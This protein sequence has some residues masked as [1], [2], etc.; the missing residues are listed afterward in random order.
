MIA[1]SSGR[2]DGDSRWWQDESGMMAF[3]KSE[4]RLLNNCK[5]L[6]E[7]DEVL[8]TGTYVTSRPQSCW[9]DH[10][11]CVTI[12]AGQDCAPADDR[13]AGCLTSL[14]WPPPITVFVAN[15]SAS[16]SGGRTLGSGENFMRTCLSGLDRA[17]HWRSGAVRAVPSVRLMLLLRVSVF[18][19]DFA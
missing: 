5:C 13:R 7:T 11:A 2:K 1:G 10:G 16:R 18:E 14:P 6:A 3:C 12:T 9:I 19:K 4:V 15:K 8:R 17:E